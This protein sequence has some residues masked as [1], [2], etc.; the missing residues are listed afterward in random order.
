MSLSVTQHVASISE[1]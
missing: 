1:Y